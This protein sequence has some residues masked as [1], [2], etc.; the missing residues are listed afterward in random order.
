[1]PQT[2]CL[3]GVAIRIDN[4]T[5]WHDLPSRHF[6]LIRALEWHEI[7]LRHCMVL[8]RIVLTTMM[9]A[10]VARCV[11]SLWRRLTLPYRIIARLIRETQWLT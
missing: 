3:M 8:T 7:D 4:T 10:S 2:E 5:Y 11:R 1:M 6:E 9:A